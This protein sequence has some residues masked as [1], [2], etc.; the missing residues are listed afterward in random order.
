MKAVLTTA[1]ALALAAAF[2]APA[3]AQQAGEHAAAKQGGQCA[4]GQAMQA[5]IE[6]N[7]Q[8]DMAA[9]KSRIDALIDN[10]LASSRTAKSGAP[11][12]SP[13]IMGKPP[14]SG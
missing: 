2:S 6:D 10:A 3:A 14:T 7:K 12:R 4:I 1:A 5:A 8:N 13:V 9:T 11:E